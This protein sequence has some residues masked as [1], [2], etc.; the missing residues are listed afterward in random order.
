[1]TVAEISQCLTLDSITA[2][3]WHVQACCGLTG[4]GSVSRTHPYTLS[5]WS[6]LSL[7]I[8]HFCGNDHVVLLHSVNSP[9]SLTASLDW[10]RSHVTENWRAA[11]SRSHFLNLSQPLQKHRSHSV[12]IIPVFRAIPMKTS[13]WLNLPTSPHTAYVRSLRV[14][15]E[16]PGVWWTSTRETWIDLSLEHTP[17]D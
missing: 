12:G 13:S 16:P 4:E 11:S 3:S 1:M 15:K 14:N 10:M 17:N 8:K 7:S 9:F 2:H 5:T 6:T